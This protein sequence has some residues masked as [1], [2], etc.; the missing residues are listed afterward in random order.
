MKS[1]TQVV[2]KI[3][4]LKEE[5]KTAYSISEKL[6]QIALSSDNQLRC[7]QKRE[8]QIETLER[9]KGLTTKAI[10]SELLLM[11]DES[12][13]EFISLNNMFRVEWKIEILK[14]LLS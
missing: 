13:S 4:Q 8:I 7:I 11:Q 3:E 2:S 1:K 9:M 6:R 12:E 10:K 5:I 14:W